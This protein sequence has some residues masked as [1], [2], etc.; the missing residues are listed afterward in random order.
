MARND[1]RFIVPTEKEEVYPYRP[2]WRSI[3]IEVAVLS[4]IT[5][6]LFT[7]VN[8]AGVEIPPRIQPIVNQ[9][10]AFL[11]LILWMLFSYLQERRAPEPRQ[12]LIPIVL[13]SA[14]AANA[15]GYPLVNE[16]FQVDRWLP[17][18]SAVNRIIGYTFTVGITQELLKYL[19]LRLVVWPDYFNTWLDA[20]AYSVAAA[21]GYATVLNLRYVLAVD[22]VSDIAA[23]R[24]LGVY[25]VQIATSILVGYG[26]AD[27][28]FNGVSLLL[29]P[30]TLALAALVTG[31]AIPI[32]AGLVNASLSLESLEVSAARPLFGL[33]L[34]LGVVIFVGVIFSFVFR[35]AEHRQREAQE[36]R[37]G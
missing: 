19:V 14:L 30:L 5:L 29:L 9:G 28:R 26:L 35:N 8:F 37:E 1:A 10:I 31:I 18:E 24:M 36:S 25:V 4:L 2:V 11:P 21:V 32:R 17:L 22:A 3:M 16:L 20:V 15:I 34:S 23:V 6:A 33:G 7:A 27:L 12:R 13:L